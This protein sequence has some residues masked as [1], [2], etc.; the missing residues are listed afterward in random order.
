MMTRPQKRAPMKSRTLSVSIDCPPP[1]VYAFVSD[2]RNFPKW[3]TAFCRSIRK[4]E[5]GWIVE[6][7]DGPVS[8]ALAPPNEHGILDHRVSPAPG[9]EILVPMRVV[10]NGSGSEVVFT[11]F[12]M[13]GMPDEKFAEDV[14]WVERDLRSLKRVLEEEKS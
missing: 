9:L 8:L 4:S 11:L 2:P 13:S 14:R 10:P 3:A 7:P 1:R 12:Q 6:T 5:E